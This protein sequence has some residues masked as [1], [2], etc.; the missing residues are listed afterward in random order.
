[1]STTLLGDTTANDVWMRGLRDGDAAVWSR[2]ARSPRLDAAY[3]AVH[4][5][6]GLP[7]PDDPLLMQPQQHGGSSSRDSSPRLKR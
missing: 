4:G 7:F 1:M 2:P 6:R 3:A 5:G